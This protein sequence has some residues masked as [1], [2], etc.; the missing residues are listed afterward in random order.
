MNTGKKS[1]SE[2]YMKECKSAE[3]KRSQQGQRRDIN[4]EKLLEEIH[5][6]INREVEV[7]VF[8]PTNLHRSL[9]SA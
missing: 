6:D 8:P 5:S 7:V 1:F 4:H 9:S 2:Q 3:D